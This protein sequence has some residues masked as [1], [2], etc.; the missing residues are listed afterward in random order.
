MHGYRKI[1]YYFTV[2]NFFGI[3]KVYM[4]NK[5]I[6]FTIISIKKVTKSN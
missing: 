3:L 6:S 4:D 5:Y 2:L 1:I